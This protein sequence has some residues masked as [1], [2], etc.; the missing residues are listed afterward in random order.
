MSCTAKTLNR[1]M[2][3][4]YPHSKL[5]RLEFQGGV[6]SSSKHKE[7]AKWKRAKNVALHVQSRREN[8]FTEDA[9]LPVRHLSRRDKRY[10]EFLYMEAY[11]EA[12]RRMYYGI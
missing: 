9:L 5:S 2:S 1:F 6:T 3:K 11:T 8:E 7:S 4:Q 12:C 10:E